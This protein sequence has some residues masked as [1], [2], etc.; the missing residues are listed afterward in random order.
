MELSLSDTYSGEPRD[1]PEALTGIKF[2]D[3]E[4]YRAKPSAAT[5]ARPRKPEFLQF[6]QMEG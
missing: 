5:E 4:E 6:L 3:V 2:R 1:I